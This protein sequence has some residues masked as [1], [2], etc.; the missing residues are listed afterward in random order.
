VTHP[1][2]DPMPMALADYAQ[3]QIDSMSHDDIADTLRRYPHPLLQAAADSIAYL[4]AQEGLLEKAQ[5]AAERA[6]IELADAKQPLD[7][8]MARLNKRVIELTGELDT[9]QRLRPDWRGYALLG[10]PARTG[11]YVMEHSAAPPDPELGAEFIIRP[12]MEKDRE[13]NR[14]VGESRLTNGGPIQP[15]TMAIRIGFLNVA[16]LDALEAQLR[17]LREENFPAALPVGVE[18]R[19]K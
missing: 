16:A 1:A 11:G 18:G 9:L 8:Q 10:D 3:E 2:Q 4:A 15:E 19:T 14:K 7:E 12:A 17:I 5:Q 6:R 13:G